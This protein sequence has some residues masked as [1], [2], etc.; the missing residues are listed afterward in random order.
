MAKE[1]RSFRDPRASAASP[2][3]E[4]AGFASKANPQD[5][6]AKRIRRIRQ[7][8]ESAGF[9]GQTRDR[10]V[11]SPQSEASGFAS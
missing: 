4:S 10:Q 7:Q 9:A 11:S 3:S 6:P 2:Q 5:S 1:N 8:S